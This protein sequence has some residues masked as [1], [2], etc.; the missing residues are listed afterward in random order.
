[1]SNDARIEEMVSELATVEPEIR[2][3]PQAYKRAVLRM[4]IER[5]VIEAMRVFRETKREFSVFSD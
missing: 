3:E 2:N 4:G 5:G 1:M